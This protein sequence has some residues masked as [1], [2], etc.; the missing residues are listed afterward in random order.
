MAILSILVF[1]GLAFGLGLLRAP[2]GRRTALLVL[3]AASVYLLQPATPLRYAGFWFPTLSIILTVL[4]GL[5]VRPRE[6]PWRQAFAAAGMLAAVVVAVGL[7]HFLLPPGWLASLRPPAWGAL[8]A[9]IAVPA[10]AVALLRG[11]PESARWLAAIVVLLLVGIF[12]VLKSESLSVGVSSAWRQL[13][14]QSTDLASPIDLTWLGFSY[15]AFRLLHVLLD[16]RAGRL[17]ALGLGEMATYALF[18]PALSAGP[19]DRAERF[20]EDL[21]RAPAITPDDA[22][23]AGRRILLG[24]VKKFVVADSLA[25]IVLQPLGAERVTAGGWLWMMLY[26]FSFQL[27]FDFSGYTDVAIGTARLV[28]IRLPENFRRPYLQPNLTAFWNSWHMTLTDWFRAYVFNPL[29]RYLR[30]RPRPWPAP[31]AIFVGQLGLMVLIGLWHGIS[32]SFVI[33]G[34]WHGLGLFIQNRWSAW[35]RTVGS[36]ISSQPWAAPLLGAGGVLLTFHFVTLGWVWFTL[37]DPA[38]AAQVLGRLFGG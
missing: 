18:F 33:W 23:E 6:A 8:V 5:I 31:A 24:L 21:R 3:S 16:W 29:I 37:P 13:S 28:G 35:T 25:M 27:Y 34:A 22:R 36:R 2:S 15:L 12:V 30:S 14:G 1:A 32:W 4:V 20:V 11:R 10:L 19:I 7:L 17:P 26:A 38:Q 9:A